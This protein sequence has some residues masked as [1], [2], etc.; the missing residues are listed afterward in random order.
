MPTLDRT[1]IVFS[2]LTDSIYIATGRDKNGAFVASAKE[3]RTSE[4]LA[5]VV[6]W[7]GPG[8]ARDIIA[9]DG[10]V[11]EVFARVKDSIASSE[12]AAGKGESE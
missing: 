7:C 9:A 8:F 1:H 2:E 3:D 4:F 6:A 5:A 12:A 10:T 11:I